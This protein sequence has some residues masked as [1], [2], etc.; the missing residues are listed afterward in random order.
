LS[1]PESA[2][3]RLLDGLA[4]KTLARVMA[5]RNRIEQGTLAPYAVTGAR[6]LVV[7]VRLGA[8]QESARSQ[9]PPDRYPNPGGPRL[10]IKTTRE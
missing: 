3:F 5:T 7:A 10:G 9:R 2:D 1:P 4:K 6:N 8:G